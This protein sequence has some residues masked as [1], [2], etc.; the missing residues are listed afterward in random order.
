MSR[1]FE[2]LHQSEKE[3]NEST[4]SRIPLPA[5]EAT[6]GAPHGLDLAGLTSIDPEPAETLMTLTD[7]RGLGAE[8][9]RVLATRLVNI[10]RETNLKVIQVTS[11]VIG[12]GKTLI[13][14]NLAA[15]LAKRFG[16]TTLLIEGDLRKPAVCREF[17]F[18]G[19]EGIGEWWRKKD[20]SILPYLRRVSDTSLCVLPAGVASHAAL[21]LQ[22]GRTVSLMSQLSAWF[23]WILIDTP[24]LLPMADSNLWARM[25]DG[26]L[27]VVR[28]GKVS[29]RAVKS[30]VDSMDS[31]KLIGVV[32][33]DATDFDR[34]SYYDKY[35]AGHAEHK[36]GNGDAKGGTDN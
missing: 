12:E 18:S 14:C 25:A 17:G 32:L 19:L 10:R 15:T 23:D 33:N 21:I 28:Q 35:Y 7:E 4:Q 29:R 16:E 27:L 31:P 30:A 34:V 13:S 22:S 6:G 1:V 36:S 8:K 11:S 26:T 3:N 2:A 20:E 24:P 5:V 9:F